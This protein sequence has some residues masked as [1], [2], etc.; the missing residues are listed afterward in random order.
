M[1]NSNKQNNTLQHCVLPPET[2]AYS[3]IKQ[4]SFSST[5]SI[6]KIIIGGLIY[7]T[8]RCAN[9]YTNI[10]LFTIDGSK[11]TQVKVHYL[12]ITDLL[13]LLTFAQKICKSF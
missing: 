12:R 8:A 9:Y 4:N 5:M 1:P 6:N 2:E 11:I 13:L 7:D 10:Q 3:S